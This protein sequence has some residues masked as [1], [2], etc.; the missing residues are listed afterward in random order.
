MIEYGYNYITG[1]TSK[2]ELF[3]AIAGLNIGFVKDNVSGNVNWKT[4]PYH[5]KGG[6]NAEVA[7]YAPLQSNNTDTHMGHVGST[8][9][10]TTWASTVVHVID[11]IK[12][13]DSIIFGIRV[14]TGVIS[15][16]CAIIAP[17]DT[18]GSWYC[19]GRNSTGTTGAAN[20]FSKTVSSTNVIQIP[21][22]SA[23]NYANTAYPSNSILIGKIFDGTE[24][25][26]NDIYMAIATPRLG[27]YSAQKYVSGNK[28]FLICKFTNVDTSMPYA[29]DITNDLATT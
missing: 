17:K 21:V 18:N 14:S 12:F 29:F 10:N 2:T 7:I 20:V 3:D 24:W 13:G 11:Y 5:L 4:S 8:S 19:A 9:G 23:N 16:A 6:S 22:T 28:T 1:T 25:V 27:N 26:D 15:Y